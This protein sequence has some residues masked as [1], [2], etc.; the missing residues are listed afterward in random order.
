M[1]GQPRIRGQRL[2]VR[3]VVKLVALYTDRAELK[4][5]FPELDDKDIRQTFEYAAANLDDEI[6][7]LTVGK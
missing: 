7:E 3:R 1:N 4:R 6:A 2:T 5:E